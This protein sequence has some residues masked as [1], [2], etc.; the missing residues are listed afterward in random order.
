MFPTHSKM[1]LSEKCGEIMIFSIMKVMEL[2]VISK[3]LGIEDMKMF[4]SHK[5]KSVVE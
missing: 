4:L 5:R 1:N 3:V 2:S